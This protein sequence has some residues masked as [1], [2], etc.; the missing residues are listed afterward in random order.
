MAGN[1]KSV[2][3]RTHITPL[4][5]SG[6]GFTLVELLVVIAMAAIVTA[7]IYRFLP[8][9]YKVITEQEAVSEMQ[10]QL[11]AAMNIMSKEIKMVGHNPNHSSADNDGLDNDADGSTDETNESG[12]ATAI[13]QADW[14]V[15][16][17]TLD[18]NSDGDCLDPND[19]ISYFIQVDG[20]GKP[21][22]RRST[23]SSTRTIA[24][25]IQALGFA[26]AFDNDG[27]GQFDKD[28]TGSGTMWAIDTD[29]DGQLDLNLDTNHDGEVNEQDNPAGEALA[30][31]VPFDKIRAVK[32]WL[33]ART[34]NP[35]SE[36]HNADTYVVANQ[37]ITP[38]D[39]YRRR[40]LST[41][42]A[43]RNMGL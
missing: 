6:G 1:R 33:L 13:S 37:R 23:T 10:Q 41:T 24:E 15:F 32:I 25:N 36:Y 3:A 35:D 17:F 18:S 4:L 31:T 26:Y 43:L 14:N 38:N 7:V 22:L 40:L 2:T 5:L 8:A 20:D 16:S 21:N 29:S 30:A 11:R 27:D 39:G 34:K 9:Q 19:N 42:V 12:C 28:P